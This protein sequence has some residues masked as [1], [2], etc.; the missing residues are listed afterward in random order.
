MKKYLFFLL[1]SSIWV[2]ET[3]TIFSQEEPITYRHITG[4]VKD[5]EN[6]PVAGA[7]VC[8]LDKSGR[9]FDGALPCVVSQANG[10][11]ALNI[12]KWDGDTYTV[13][14]E[15]FAKGYPDTL[16]NG[17]FEK[18]FTESQIA[19]VDASTGFNSVEIRVIT[20]AGRVIL[21][22]VD[23]A[24]DQPI[25]S[26]SVKVCRIDDSRLCYS[27]S[28][29]FPNGKFEFL[30]PD[31]PVTLKIELWNGSEWKEWSAIDR[32]NRKIGLIQVKLGETKKIKIRLRQ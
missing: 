22:I 12:Q 26:G 29:G 8:G 23:D 6:H 13:F 15:D 17:L 2:C 16:L 1:L 4:Y 9:P 21:K 3:I 31:S 11:F 10:S 24:S 14:V 7:L 18:S 19:D 30:T 5:S 32:N 27:M 20:K 28:A 25:E